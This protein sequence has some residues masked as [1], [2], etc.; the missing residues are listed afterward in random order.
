MP[1]MADGCDFRIKDGES[2]IFGALLENPSR[3]KRSNV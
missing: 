1:G 2:G 3:E